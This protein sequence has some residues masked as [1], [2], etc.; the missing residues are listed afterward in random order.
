MLTPAQLVTLKANILASPDLAAQPNNDDGHFEIAKLYNVADVAFIVWRTS[1]SLTAVGRAFNGAELAAKSQ[2]D[3][4]R[5][6]AL[7]HYLVEGVNPSLADNRAF[8]DDV[9]SGT[10]GALTRTAL[11]ALW[12]RLSTR[13]EKLFAVGTGTNLAPATMAFEGLV[14]PGEVAAARALP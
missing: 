7:A 13:A 10:S 5:L 1:V 11:L 4:T 12:K 3:Q 14:T 9:F 6:I 8:F 2:A